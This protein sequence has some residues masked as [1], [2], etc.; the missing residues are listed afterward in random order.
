MIYK[1]YNWLKKKDEE[2]AVG[3][4]VGLAWGLV[5][6]LAGGLAVGIAGGLAWG[7]AVGIAVGIVGGLAWG[8]AGG[9][10]WGIAG[11]LAWGLAWGLVNISQLMSLDIFSII[12]LIIITIILAEILYG[13]NKKEKKITWEK[14]IWL[15]IDAI[16]T[17]LLIIINGLNARWAVNHI[18]IN[19][20]IVLRWVGYI[21]AGL[22]ILGIIGGV[23]YLWLLWNKKRLTR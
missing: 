3:I 11:G 10:A 1:T 17:S 8:I 14:V 9:L 21:G 6:G 2:L 13:F 23:I 18:K 12:L 20:D 22:I 5:G 19:F 7:I 15:K 4:A 16:F